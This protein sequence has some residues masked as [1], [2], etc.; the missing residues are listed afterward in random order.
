MVINH[1]KIPILFGHL[2]LIKVNLIRLII[3]SSIKKLTISFNYNLSICLSIKFFK[4]YFNHN[5]NKY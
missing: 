1:Y 3:V 5:D 4:K 2:Y